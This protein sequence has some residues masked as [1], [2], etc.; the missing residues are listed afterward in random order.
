MR[1]DQVLTTTDELQVGETRE[2]HAGRRTGRVA[3]L[4]RQILVENSTPRDFSP[5]EQLSAV[6]LSS[7]DM[8]RLMLAI[9]AEFGITIASSDITPGNFYSVATI[10]ALIARISARR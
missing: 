8:V 1:A 6:G 7:L 3:A 2:E 9:E 4:V 10:E 5:G